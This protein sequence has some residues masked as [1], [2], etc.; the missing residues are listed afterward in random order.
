MLWRIPMHQK[1][2]ALDG[3]SNAFEGQTLGKACR[4][5]EWK[6]D[7]K[8]YFFHHLLGINL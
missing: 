3:G 7:Q 5:E 2:G 4:P 1:V 6:Q 8:D